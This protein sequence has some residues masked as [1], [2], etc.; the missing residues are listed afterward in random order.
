VQIQTYVVQVRD[1][2]GNPI[3][4]GNADTRVPVQ[5][6]LWGANDQHGPTVFVDVEAGLTFCVNMQAE[7]PRFTYHLIPGNTVEIAVPT[8]PVADPYA[9]T[10]RTVRVQPDMGAEQYRVAFG[11]DRR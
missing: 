3:N 10:R 1:H 8:A 11:R 5:P 9:A 6:A 4:M 2:R 7:Y